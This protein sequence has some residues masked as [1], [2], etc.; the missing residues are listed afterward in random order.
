MAKHALG[1]PNAWEHSV[2]RLERLDRENLPEP[3]AIVFIGSSSF[4]LWSSLENDMLPLRVLNRG[5]GGA[6]LQD[7]INHADR[8]VAPLVPSAVVVF[9]GTNDMAGRNPATPDYVK[10][11]FSELVRILRAIEPDVLIFYVAITPSAA[12]WDLWPIAREANTKIKALVATDSRAR[13]IDLGPALLTSDGTPDSTLYRSDKLHPSKAGYTVWTKE[14][15]SVL[16]AEPEI[17]ASV[18]V[19]D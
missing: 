19:P 5:F 9:A 14:I 10:D 17:A 18:R 1:L 4:T 3:G 15:R 7:V 2:R 8:I 6:L 13:F 11:R 16:I 12:H